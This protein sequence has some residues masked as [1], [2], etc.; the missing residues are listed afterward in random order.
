MVRVR[1]SVSVSVSVGV[2]V[3]GP[4]LIRTLTLTLGAPPS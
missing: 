3:G 4:T 2:R 1:V